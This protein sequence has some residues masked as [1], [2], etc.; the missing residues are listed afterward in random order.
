MHF[1]CYWRIPLEGTPETSDRVELLDLHDVN[2]KHVN[3]VNSEITAEKA[4]DVGNCKLGLLGC[5]QNFPALIPALIS[6][7]VH[8]QCSKWTQD[9]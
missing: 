8:N 7:D 2:N 3:F 9:T 1:T 4:S 5:C 6:E